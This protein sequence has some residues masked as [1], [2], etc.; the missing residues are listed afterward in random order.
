[1]ITYDTVTVSGDDP[2]AAHEMAAFF[3]ACVGAVRPV[4]PREKGF[5]ER[6]RF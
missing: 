2:E 1:M 3:V 4:F 5:T 6:E